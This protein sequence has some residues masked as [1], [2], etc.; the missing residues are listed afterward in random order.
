MI[1]FHQERY[2]GSGYPDGLKGEEIPLLARIIGMVDSFD[3]LTTDRPYRKA[4]PVAEALQIMEKETEL[5]LWD[6]K[7]FEV[8]KTI[9]EGKGDGRALHGLDFGQPKVISEMDLVDVDHRNR[10]IF[11]CLPLAVTWDGY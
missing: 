7:I 2:D 8:M 3:A 11:I 5:G 9:L 10:I 6:P 4:I 1:R